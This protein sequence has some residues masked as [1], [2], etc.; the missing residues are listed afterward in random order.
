MLNNVRLG[1][2]FKTNVLDA[3]GAKALGIWVSADNLAIASARKGFNPST[4]QAGSSSMYRYSPLSTV[5][6]GLRVKF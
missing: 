3:I 2:N 5:S 6:A 4:H 1:Y